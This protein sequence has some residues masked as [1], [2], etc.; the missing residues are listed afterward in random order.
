[1]EDTN[2]ISTEIDLDRDV[3]DHI[4][5]DFNDQEDMPGFEGT[6]KSLDDLCDEHPDFNA[7]LN[8]HW[9]YV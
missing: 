6:W 3:P 4:E 1:M 2:F 9:E 7:A 5:E 8:G